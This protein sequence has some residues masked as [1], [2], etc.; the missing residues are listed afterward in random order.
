MKQ[1]L[2]F[3]FV[4][5]FII[6]A[7]CQDH[8]PKIHFLLEPEINYSFI[9]NKNINTDLFQSNLSLGFGINALIDLNINSKFNIISGLRITSSSYNYYFDI[10]QY[11]TNYIGFSIP[12]YLEYSINNRN[13]IGIGTDLSYRTKFTSLNITSENNII[14]S[15]VTTVGFS[16]IVTPIILS[17]S[18]YFKTKKNRNYSLTFYMKKGIQIQETINLK[19]YQNNT[20]L[21]ES[22]FNYKGTNIS[23][24]FRYYFN[25]KKAHNKT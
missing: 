18:H 25:K 2:L 21:N 24:T 9:E 16:T 20:I 8:E 23:V 17:Y 10:L 4:T 6:K 11:R 3:L 15:D 7:N 19:E 14:R 13:R 12:L 22:S 1:L 5:C